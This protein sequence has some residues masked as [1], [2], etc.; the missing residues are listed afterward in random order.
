MAAQKK[1]KVLGMAASGCP[2]CPD[3]FGKTGYAK[4]AGPHVHTSALEV[5]LSL[6]SD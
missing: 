6:V 2:N 5:V 3:P 4:G 1:E